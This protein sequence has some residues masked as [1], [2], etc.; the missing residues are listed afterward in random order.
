MAEYMT[1]L[2]AEDVRQAASTMR[3]AA[4]DMQR[5]AMSI[6]ES[7]QRALRQFEDCVLRLEALASQD[8]D[9]G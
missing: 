6:D 3:S 2:G 5:A 8:K 9:D 7:M 1:L 4:D